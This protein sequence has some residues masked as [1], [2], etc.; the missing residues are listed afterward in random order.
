MS[1][2]LYYES[3]VRK[4]KPP[5]PPHA[6][7]KNATTARRFPELARIPANELHLYFPVP[8]QEKKLEPINTPPAAAKLRLTDPLTKR[9]VWKPSNPAKAK[10]SIKGPSDYENRYRPFGADKVAEQQ[11]KQ[12]DKELQRKICDTDFTPSSASGAKEGVKVDY[13]L[14]SQDE[15]GKML[16]S[17]MLE[18]RIQENKVALN[19]KLTAHQH[20]QKQK[21]ITARSVANLRRLRKANDDNDEDDDASVS[22]SPESTMMAQG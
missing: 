3:I 4:K 1:E 6:L 2:R 21:M 5:P 12:R 8:K 9:P 11:K 15:F 16:Q 7:F 19:Q 17:K 20:R 13:Y 18:K 22:F 14:Y 10:E